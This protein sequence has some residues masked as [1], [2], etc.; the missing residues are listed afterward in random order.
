MIRGA[1]TRKAGLVSAALLTVLGVAGL[2]DPAPVA[3]QTRD[4]GNGFKDHGVAAPISNHRGIVST[5]DGEGRNVVLA[6]MM[7]HRGVYS[8]LMVDAETGKSEQYP[9]P[10]NNTKKDSPFA[11]VLS[12]GNRFYSHFGDHFVEFDPVKRAF[13]FHKKTTPQMAMGM[14]EDDNGKIWSVTY[15]NSGVA[16]YD[17]KSGE[18][19]D[20]GSVY[21][22]NW[23]QYQRYVAADDSG[24][25]YFAVGNTKTQIIAFNPETKI[26]E[27]L[28]PEEERVHGTPFIYRDN[29]GKVYAELH[30]GDGKWVELY[31]GE[32]KP[33]ENHTS[34]PKRIITDTQ[35]L[36]HKDFPDG[37]QLQALNL[38][39]RTITVIDA[40][41]SMPRTHDIAYESEGAV[42]MGT[43]LAPNGTLSGGT[44]FPMRAFSYDPVKDEMINRPA[45]GQWNTVQTSY[46]LFYVGG[47]P[48]GYL[49]EWDPSKPWVHTV[50]NDPKTNP[51]LLYVASPSIHRTHAL[52]PLADR[53]KVL[54]AGTPDYGMTGGGLLIW[55]LKTSTPTL[56]THEQLLKDQSIFTMV[57]L[58][59]GKVLGGSTTVAGTGGEKLASEGELFIFDLATQKIEWHEAVFPGTQTYLQ[60]TTGPEGLVYGIADR[61]KFFVFDPEKRE[62]VSSQDLGE[63]VGQTASQQGPRVLIHGDGE[64]YML[65]RNGIAKIDQA[66][67]KVSRIVD[68]PTP[69]EGGGAFFNGRLYYSH[70]SRLYSYDVSKTP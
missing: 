14:T 36:V 15:P 1:I 53:S 28:I 67:H 26:A 44:A 57:E 63:D 8:L 46:D 13:T 56:L 49:L 51:R 25:V 62:V 3:G 69:I 38:P 9:L 18:F 45:Y 70:G 4:L 6:W 64:L 41:T 65:L 68:T 32:R 23:P 60:L 33:V 55:D 54:M 31:K 27:P 29:N 37:A 47:Y 2:A 20:Y 10:F 48:R 39:D 52:L 24:M 16:S 11:S 35:A 34:S 21:Q 17:P 43:E 50:A 59:N 19:N 42:I 40:Q 30:K 12:S 5:V 61:T 58:G 22:Q 7:D 66:E